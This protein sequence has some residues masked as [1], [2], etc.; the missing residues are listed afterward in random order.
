MIGSSSGHAMPITLP[1]TI[2]DTLR[3]MGHRTGMLT[4]T[5]PSPPAPSTTP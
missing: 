5:R 3:I 4:A 1:I 2:P